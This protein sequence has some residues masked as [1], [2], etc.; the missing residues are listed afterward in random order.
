MNDLLIIVPAYNEE[1]KLPQL[2]KQLEEY[3]DYVLIVDDGSTDESGKIVSKFGFNLIQNHENK[4]IAFSIYT[5]LLYAV[6]HNFR[7]AVLMDADGQHD[8]AYIEEFSKK[9]NSYDFVTGN[10]FHSSTIA[11]DIK[12][13][14]N[15]LGA[16]LVNKIFETD[17]TDIS[18]GYKGFVISEPLIAAVKDSKD[19]SIVFDLLFYALQ[20]D[21]TVGS[22]NM[23]AIYDYGEFLF[24][25]RREIKSL[26][27][28]LFKIGKI[29]DEIYEIIVAL[30]EA[31]EA[32]RDFKIE[33]DKI[34]FLGIY[35]DKYD[36]YI[37]QSEK[38]RFYLR[39]KSR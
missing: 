28:A 33:V 38:A 39:T 23:Q 19:Y 14:S 36:G 20:N 31:T 4:G 11:P 7:Y 18:C 21:I 3:K 24:T 26:L 2:L 13:N 12:W 17:F 5:A 10:R 22:V 25:K 16:V 27:Y 29:P 15:V 30:N 37:I 34:D 9:L 32:K 1:K 6:K 8:V 35:L